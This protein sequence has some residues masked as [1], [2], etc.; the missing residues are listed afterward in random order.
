MDYSSLHQPLFIEPAKMLGKIHEMLLKSSA[1]LWSLTSHRVGLTTELTEF[2]KEV[3]VDEIHWWV[4]IKEQDPEEL[5]RR[6]KDTLVAIQTLK[7]EAN[8]LIN[9]ETN[10]YGDLISI[11]VNFITSQKKNIETLYDYVYWLS[12]KNIFAPSILFTYRVWGSTR[13]SQRDIDVPNNE[14]EYLLKNIEH[15]IEIACGL[16]LDGYYALDMARMRIEADIAGNIDQ[17]EGYDHRILIPQ[18]R[19]IDQTTFE[20]LSEFTTYIE[21]IRNS[22]RNII[23]EIEKN[24]AQKNLLWSDT[25]WNNFIIKVRDLQKPESL[26]DFKRTLE[27]WH[28]PS[29]SDPKR[30]AEK[31]L[32]FAEEIASLANSKGGV[33][34]IGITDTFPRQT[35]G[36]GNEL[37]EI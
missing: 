5:F 8:K 36:I 18:K 4:F 1:G 31:E 25:F 19:L 34:I 14:N 32:K 35:V 9:K 21:M 15:Y 33:L 17:E 16:W 10:S 3:G 28:I 20:V 24:N 30:K 13:R 23:L 26:W 29:K 37:T 22:L 7:S 11:L 6:T 12:E 2:G 27:M